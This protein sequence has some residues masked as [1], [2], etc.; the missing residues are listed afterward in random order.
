MQDLNTYEELEAQSHSFLPSAV[1]GASGQLN[2]SAAS[3]FGKTV[4]PGNH[5]IECC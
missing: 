1:D 4:P 3:L 5:L 2:T